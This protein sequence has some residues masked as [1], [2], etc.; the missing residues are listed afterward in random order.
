[1]TLTYE[2]TNHVLVDEYTAVVRGEVPRD[3]LPGWLAGT[4]QA[5]YDYLRRAGIAPTGPPFARY[6][7]L[8][9]VVAVEAGFPVPYEIPGDDL[10]KSSAL[11]AGHAAVTTHIGGYEDLDRAYLA[12]VSWLDV[13]GYELAGPHWEVYRT[14]PSAEPDPTRWRTDIVVPYRAAPQPT[15]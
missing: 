3:E 9:G 7:F 8:A 4:F 12:I 5:V 1:M 6:T 2:I 14:D 15:A 11:P 13:H 10:V